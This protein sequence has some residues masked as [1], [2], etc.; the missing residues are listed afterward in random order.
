M[1]DVAENG[2]TVLSGTKLEDI[3]DGI[4]NKRKASSGAQ[5]SG[6]RKTSQG[7]ACAASR[8]RRNSTFCTRAAPGGSKRS[9]SQRRP[10]DHEHARD[11]GASFM[12]VVPLSLEEIFI[13]ELGGEHNEV[14]TSSFNPTLITSLW[15]RF[16]PL[17]MAYFAIWVIALPL[18][19]RLARN[20][21]S[22][23]TGSA[24][25]AD[26]GANVGQFILDN[27]INGGTIMSLFF[28]VLIAMAAFSYLYN[29]RSVSMMRAAR[30]T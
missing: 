18:S 3:C 5:P 29:A 21:R 6:Y 30:Q 24:T 4:M 7:P 28:C 26:C 12:D 2:T 8:C 19:L 9:L 11:T 17:F 16:W 27:G 22:L 14:K 10:G 20:L 13:Y 23:A 25:A 15:K 1:A